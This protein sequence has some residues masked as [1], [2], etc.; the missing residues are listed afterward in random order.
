MYVQFPVE[1][2]VLRAEFVFVKPI[3]FFSFIDRI[4]H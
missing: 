1:Y 3:Q 4:I 2:S